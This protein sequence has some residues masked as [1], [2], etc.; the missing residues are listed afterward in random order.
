MKKRCVGRV[1]NIRK[2]T[3]KF[4]REEREFLMKK[5]YEKGGVSL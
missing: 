1:R 5:G 2:K 4:G 3:K